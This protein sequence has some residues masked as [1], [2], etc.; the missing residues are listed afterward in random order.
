M[1]CCAARLASCGI[2]LLRIG[3]VGTLGTGV[4][5]GSTLGTGCSASTLGRG[6][7]WFVDV[8]CWRCN[9]FSTCWT[10]VFNSFKLWSDVLSIFPNS[11]ALQFA[12]AF[13]SLSE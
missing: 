8:T 6:C 7:S 2:G 13:M 1:R 4:R 3:A 10:M 11:I 12:S 9:L 5:I